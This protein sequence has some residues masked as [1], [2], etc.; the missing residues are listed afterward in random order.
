MSLF[1]SVN[2]VGGEAGG[3]SK[4]GEGC[5]FRLTAKLV[6]GTGQAP[7]VRLQNED[8][9]QIEPWRHF[10]GSHILL[11]EVDIVHQQL[12]SALLSR[13]GL[14]VDVAGDGQLAVEAIRR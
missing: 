5:T 9:V 2:V 1:C 4:L 8:E 10:A 12:A 6:K 13:V 7:E 3:E 11:V 14:V